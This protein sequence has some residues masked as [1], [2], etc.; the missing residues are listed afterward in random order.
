MKIKIL[1]AIECEV[2]KR[3]GELLI[4]LLSFEAVYWQQGPHTKQRKVYRKQVFSHKGKNSWY[5]YTGLLPRVKAWCKSNNIPLGIEG[6]ELKIPKQADPFLQG[7]TFREDQL[8]LIDAAC[9]ANRGI[10][11]SA[12]GSGKT[13]MQLGVISCYPKS[14]A[15]IL[16]HTTSIVAQTF[17]ELKD[18]GFKD[19][20]MFGAGN[21]ASKPKARI[22]VSTM[23]TWIKLNLEDYMDRYDI[24]L[25]DEAHHLQQSD[26]TYSKILSQM[27]SPIRLG[28]TATTRTNDEAI[29][30]SEGLLGPVLDRVTIDEAAELNILARPKLRLI[31]AKC[32]PQIMDIRKYQDVYTFGIVENKYR[33]RQIVEIV[34]EFFNQEMTTLIFVTQIEHGLILVDLLEEQLNCKVPFVRGEMPEEQRTAIKNKLITNKIKV[35]VATTSWRE[36]VDIPNL[37][38]VVLSGGG[39]S[40][41]QTLQG[42]GRGL[43]KTKDKDEVLIIDFLDLSH[44]HLIRQTGER[45]AIYSENSWI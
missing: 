1:D 40:E 37:S 6:K 9:K 28:W 11:V 26:S 41:I 24:L 20:E 38:T 21:S 14:R 36:G 35:V 15:L 44:T 18:F 34:E 13:L 25:L 8:R 12:T 22:T 17:K 39:K 19:I 10:I 23:Q 4:P 27:L 45:L 42:I 30:I 2:S 3:D 43:R 33:N 16:A 7:I 31:K 32:S 5:F 29:L